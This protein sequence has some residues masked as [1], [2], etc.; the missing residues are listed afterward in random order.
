MPSP[1]ISDI[2]VEPYNVIW[3]MHNL[4]EHM[5]SVVMLDN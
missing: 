4:V 1:D 3:A 2:I 5:N